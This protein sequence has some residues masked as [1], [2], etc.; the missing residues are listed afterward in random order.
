MKKF[1]FQIFFI[2]LIF[3]FQFLKGEYFQIRIIKDE[4]DLPESFCSIWQAGD[5][6]IKTNNYYV[7]IGGTHRRYNDFLNYPSGS[8]YG[9]ILSFVPAG[10]NLINDLCAGSPVIAMNGK[11]DYPSYNSLKQIETENGYLKFEATGTYIKNEKKAFIK[12][13]YLFYPDYGRI[14]IVS[15]IKNTGKNEFDEFDYYLYFNAF[16]CYYFNPF[17]EI[18]HPNLNFR[19]YQKKGY[20]M[21]R[22]NLNPYSEEPLPGKLAPGE[23]Y[24]VKYIFL[25]DKDVERLLENIYEIL[26]IE[27]FPVYINFQNYNGD[28]MELKIK[29]VQSSSIFFKSFLK[30]KYLVNIRLPEGTYRVIANFF[31]AVCEKIITVHKNEKTFCTIE[32]P[33]LGTLKIKISNSNGE[34]VPGK[35]TFIGLYPTKTPYFEP[36]NPIETGRCSESFKNSCLPPEE[37][38]EIKIPV[39][40]YLVYASRGP[41]YSIDKK[42]IE[43]LKDDY[44]ELNFIIE[45]VIETPDLVSFDPHMHTQNSDGRLKIEERIKSVIAE[46]VEVAVSTDHNYI[47]DYSTTLKELG[48]E[49]Y[50]IV[51]PGSEISTSGIVHFNSYPLKPNPEH[52]N[53]GAINPVAEEASTL[54]K[55]NKEKEPNAIIQLNHPRYGTL[56]YFNNYEL[57][58]EYASYAE[59]NFDTSFDVIE[60]MNGPLYSGGNCQTIRDWLNLL[61]RGYYFP[62]VGSSDSHVIDGGEPGYSRT[63][64]FYENKKGGINI[65]SLINALKK[66]HSFITNGPLIDFKINGKYTI[67]DFF[68]DKDGK[69]DIQI[70]VKSAP[71]IS[72][73]EV[74]LIINGERKIIFPIKAKI[75]E[76]LKLNQK[77]SLYLKRDSYIIVEAFGN[78]TL[79]PVVQQPARDGDPEDAILPYAITNP[80]FIDI[81]G[82][83]RFDPPLPHKI[84]LI[85]NQ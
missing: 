53:N 2:L 44:M 68:T 46:G 16:H 18:A 60:I 57:D 83:G 51:I 59:K 22:I 84:K 81:D 65:D 32:S 10:E 41:E 67:G 38:L 15:E 19:V 54:F 26:N 33:P 76:I 4:K 47:T 37:G 70:K 79:Y 5:Y 50:L 30:N 58:P 12:T 82:N 35:V 29:D 52:E 28:L 69:I 48:L 77:I 21:A 20:Y 13:D 62:G 39:G 40:T 3:S 61:N 45:R 71:W 25:V 56:G 80:V 23:T 34:F 78:K 63:Y 14:D 8:A 49:K 55:R 36:E 66:G 64:I 17:D 85:E 43:V 73:N 42:I 27:S 75:N 9:S 24:E 7:I 74:R 1:K 72:I 31:P 6:L 11:R